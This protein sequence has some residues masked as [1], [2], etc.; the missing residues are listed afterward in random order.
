[1]KAVVDELT[2]VG[3]IA[4]GGDNRGLGEGFCGVGDAD[5]GSKECKEVSDNDIL[6][7]KVEK[8]LVAGQLQ[9]GVTEDGEEAPNR[10]GRRNRP[11]MA[12]RRGQRGSWDFFY[13]RS[14]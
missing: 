3:A 6:G 11:R 2:E 10:R 7:L 13:M 14:A 4:K 9:R 5:I 8:Q 1:M 12:P